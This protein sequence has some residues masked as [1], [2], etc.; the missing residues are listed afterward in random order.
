MNMERTA[1]FND[2]FRK[3]IDLKMGEFAVSHELAELSVKHQNAVLF[4]VMD[5]EQFDT[6]EHN[7]GTVNVNV[8]NPTVFSWQIA[9]F[10]GPDKMWGSSDPSNPRMT[11]RYLAIMPAD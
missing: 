3:I 6:P 1:L 4:A 11:W 2:A 5:T 9:C 8:P 7:R 10:S